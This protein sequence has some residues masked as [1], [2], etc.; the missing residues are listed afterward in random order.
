MKKPEKKPVRK[1][2]I[3]GQAIK[4][5]NIKIPKIENPVTIN[6][7]VFKQFTPHLQLQLNELVKHEKVIAE[8]L[9]D[10]HEQELFIK[11]PKE[12]FDKHKI[13]VSPFIERKL[14]DFDL[15]LQLP[16]EEFLM[17]NGERLKPN[18]SINIIF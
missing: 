11:K 15:N 4:P 18:I 10:P 6:P 9:R 3:I 8:K 16:A 12:F 2:E 13:K 5:I 7:E 14:K 1:P 17:P